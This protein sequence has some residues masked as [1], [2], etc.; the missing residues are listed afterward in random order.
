[1][2]EAAQGDRL[3]THLD[4]ELEALWHSADSDDFA[5]GIDAFFEKRAPKFEGH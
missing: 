2:N 3:D 5:E 1:M 4:R